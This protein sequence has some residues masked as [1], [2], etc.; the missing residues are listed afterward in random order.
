M[1]ESQ[2]ILDSIQNAKKQL[3]LAFFIHQMMQ[4]QQCLERLDTKKPT[5]GMYRSFYNLMLK[6]LAGFCFFL[7]MGENSLFSALTSTSLH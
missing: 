2:K 7:K 5:P 3:M 4:C 1:H 6:Y